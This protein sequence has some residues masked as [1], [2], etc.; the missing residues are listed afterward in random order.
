MP[1]KKR[2]PKLREDMALAIAR[3]ASISQWARDNEIPDRTA[4][5]WAKKREFKELVA[6]HRRRLADRVIGQLSR[7]AT[8]AVRAIERLMD[9]SPNDTVRL[10]AARSILTE[11]VNITGFS[12]LEQRI[13]ELERQHEREHRGASEEA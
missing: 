7:I 4:R 3:G 13:T 8:K 1:G 12:E 9:N 5:E 11:L 2:G 6:E 10:N